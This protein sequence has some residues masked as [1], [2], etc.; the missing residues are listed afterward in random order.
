MS[1]EQAA[2]QPGES[3]PGAQTLD[4]RA[5]DDHSGGNATHFTH[6]PHPHI[7]ARRREGPVKVADQLPKHSAIARINSRLALLI[8]VGV[9]SMWCAYLFIILAF[10]SFPAAVRSHDTIIIV[11][12]ISQTLFQ[13]VLLPV[14]IVGQNIQGE[15][16]DRRA[17]QTYKD[18][19]AVLHEAMQIQQHL[20]EQDKD[21]EM[22]QQCLNHIIATLRDA[23]PAVAA[24]LPPAGAS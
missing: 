24:E 21:L 15:A 11:A 7:A 2:P 6:V 19:E 1:V 14:I 8:T 17:E 10:V 13:L 20:H 12:W 23:F 4:H 3:V 16:A 5:G 18:A 22:Q 9:G